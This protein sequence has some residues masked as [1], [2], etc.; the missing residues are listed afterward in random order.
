M[1][2][3][4]I[5]GVEMEVAQ[6]TESD[7][8]SARQETVQPQ[9]QTMRRDVDYNWSEARRKLD[10]LE[11]EN[12]EQ[13]ELLHQMQAQQT[14]KPIDEIAGLDDDDIITVKQ[15]RSSVSKIA[16]QVAEEVVRQRDAATVDDRLRSKFSD[17][18]QV[19]SVDN[20][21]T[22]QKNDPELA[23]SLKML[24][25]DPYKQSVAAYKLLKNMGYGP[26]VNNAPTT[27][28]KKKASDNLQKPV[29]IN[30]VSKQSAIGNMSMF[31][32]GLTKDL[33][34]KLYQQMLKDIE[35]G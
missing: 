30:A 4:E 14:P 27:F 28:E 1:T 25:D 5:M 32:N 2:D 8:Q 23:Q 7:E 11:R 19:V 29:S 9:Q 34:D 6:S 16:R 3:D 26:S 20:I 12:R 15:H 18:D 35:N 13:R 10:Q 24:A 22:L 21:E 31:E 17:Y 33:K